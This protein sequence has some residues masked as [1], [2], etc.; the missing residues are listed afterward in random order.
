MIGSEVVLGDHFGTCLW[1]VMEKNPERVEW[2]MARNVSSEDRELLEK[3]MLRTAGKSNRCKN[4]LYHTSLNWAPN[5][6][7]SKKQMIDVAE[8][9]L[10]HMGLEEYQTLLVAHNDT[11]YSHVHVVINRVHPQTK[12]AWELNTYI[13]KGRDRKF[14]KFHNER[15]QEFLRGMEKK[16]GWEFVPGKYMEGQ[17]LDVSPSAGRSEYHRSKR[18]KKQLK[19]FGMNP[20]EFDTRSVRLRAMEVKDE[21]FKCEN[22]KEIDEV[23]DKKGLWIRAEGQGAV[24]TDGVH[25]VKASDINRHLSGG[26]LENKFGEDLKAYTKERDNMI[27]ADLGYR[28]LVDWSQGLEV[29]ELEKL[30]A[31]LEEEKEN[32]ENKFKRFKQLEEKYEKLLEGL[33]KHFRQA[34]Q[35]GTGAYK[36]FGK[37]LKEHKGKEMQAIEEFMAH[38]ERFG[39]VKDS[40]HIN[41]IGEEFKEAIS[42][43]DKMKGHVKGLSGKT[44]ADK[45][46]SLQ[47]S[48][49]KA[50]KQ[51]KNVNK[52]IVRHLK[53]DYDY[54]ELYDPQAAKAKQMVKGGMY[55]A[56]SL[57]KAMSSVFV[58]SKSKK[59]REASKLMG[60]IGLLMV[61]PGRGAQKILKQAIK[62]GGQNLFK[63]GRDLGRN[64]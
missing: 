46:R 23:L 61:N 27:D 26:K 44:M 57:H 28:Q 33:P 22:F 30:S 20:D 58:N 47:G 36:A 9:Y 56:L 54:D 52:K 18:K 51:L 11:D 31:L 5:D 35:D 29:A 49:L 45:K 37:H 53:S 38:P 6:N 42:A 62:I 32:K 16:Y 48:S 7:P 40:K 19:I 4:P 21:L 55:K 14:D 39:Q 17:T 3:Q 13:G 64:K 10:K 15:V 1:Y 63:S 59:N 12:K 2:K 50:K 34:Y 24:F 41:R 8:G 25:Q 43:R 60:N